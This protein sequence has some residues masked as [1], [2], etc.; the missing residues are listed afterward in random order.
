M[1]PV[2]AAAPQPAFSSA[3]FPAPY[4]DADH[5]HPA[6]DLT[7]RL[8][9]DLETRALRSQ[10]Q[11]EAEIERTVR[12]RL[13]PPP[14]A[15]NSM[16]PNGTVRAV[17]ILVDFPDAPA[18][19]GDGRA[20]VALKLFGAGDPGQAPYE[21]LRSYYLRSSSGRLAIDGQVYGW[22]HS[23]RTRQYY[24]ERAAQYQAEYGGA[25]GPM[26]GQVCARSDLLR[27]A[28]AAL[29][30]EIDFSGC[31][32]D[33]NGVV[34]AV[35][36][37]FAGPPDEWRDLF[38]GCQD[39]YL[40]H[41]WGTDPARYDG[42]KIG[43]YAFSPYAEAGMSAFA[44]RASIHE[45]GHLLGLPD[46]Y[47]YAPAVGPGGGLGGWDMM[48]SQF[49]D[50]NAFSKYLLG[51]IAP[52]IVDRSGRRIDLAPATDGG[53]AVLVMPGATLD[54]YAEFFLVEC[55]RSGVGNDPPFIYDRV[56]Q[57]DRPFGPSLMI[58]HVDA[59]LDPLGRQFACDNSYT[60]HK[61]LRLMEADGAEQLETVTT[62]YGA[63]GH[64]DDLYGPGGLFGPGTVPGS[65]AYDG[66]PTNVTVG[67]VERSASGVRAWIGTVP[68]PV[69]P[70]RGG[71]GV[72]RDLD[73]D[74]LFEDI[75]GNGRADFADV[76][77]F[78][79][80]MDWIAANEPID[81]F[82][83]AGNGRIDFADA[84]RLFDRI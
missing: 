25:Y 30:D 79:G 54:A 41:Y 81:A 66:R 58:W 29:D 10:G 20:E 69:V 83:F 75:N 61:L 64:V 40:W 32:A 65:A 71:T 37:L 73:G 2:N 55:R 78:F 52:T 1:P 49:G 14:A 63:F 57:T 77:L 6:P 34:D 3:P 27:E 23:N 22:F 45:T 53:G 13:A 70:V 8:H 80:Q 26:V 11:S 74:A 39:V 15:Q 67:A 84:V 44:P 36:L 59:R 51:W 35:Y 42:L 50:H 62:I 5:L 16:P 47:D 9:A 76:V 48:D 19:S 7:Y 31:D 60:P 56:V 33:G 72:P 28:V 46:Y 68:D 21:S 38:W 18:P 4:W 43:A 82:D 17:A 24:R 12:A